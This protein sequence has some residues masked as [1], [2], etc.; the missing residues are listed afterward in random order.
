MRV[1]VTGATGFVGRALVPA[2]QHEGHRV[3]VFARSAR[4]ARARLGAD[5]EA[6]DATEGADALT[7]ALQGCDAVINLAGEP[8]A[9]GRWTESRRTALRDSRVAATRG[10]VQA[11]ARMAVKPRVLVS[12]S[13][14]GFYGNRGAE[15]LDER[16]QAGTGFLA[17]LCVEWEA[18]ALA[19]RT[20]G[21][22]VVLPRIGV[23]LGRDGGAL[24]KMLPPFSFGL[25][26]PMGSG[27]QFLPWIHLHDLVRLIVA[28]LTDDRFDGPVNAVA[29][30]A[31]TNREFAKTLGRALNRPAVVPI[32]SL[33]LRLAMGDAASVVLDGQRVI[34]ALLT[35]IGFSFIYRDL[36]SAFRD[37]V[38]GT[39]VTLS[40]ITEPIDAH[41]SVIGREY[42]DRRRPIYELRTT[43]MVNAPLAETFEFFSKAENLGL[44]TPSSMGFL[45]TKQPAAIAENVQ[46]DYKVRVNG[47][48]INWRTR[49]VTWRPGERFVDFQEKGPYRAWWHEHAFFDRGDKTLMEDRVCYA[50]PMGPLG[51]MANAFFIKPVLR[52]IFRYRSDVIALRFGRG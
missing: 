49:I 32:P 19:A 40:T 7:N 48:P 23:V 35:R 42:L 38:G 2:L 39:D 36:A 46:I 27:E 52:Q 51:R 6:V 30:E 10:L 14:V 18:A 29:P 11:I 3:V 1:L 17:D 4:R 22:R 16:A 37:I 34:P 47:L 26:G 15:V 50:P 45:I 31:V 9:G 5:I 20:L 33:A 24:G 8:I 12:A 21:L 44:I 43:T 25:G 13:A 41:G 28:A